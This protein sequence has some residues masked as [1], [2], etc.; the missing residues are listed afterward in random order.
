MFPRTPDLLNAI[1]N[2]IKLNEWIADIKKEN[3]GYIVEKKS[4]KSSTLSYIQKKSLP[5]P[6]LDINLT[7]DV[8]ATKINNK[9]VLQLKREH[10][11]G[12]NIS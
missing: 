10:L 7:D 3:K 2:E 9:T 11:K 6:K 8:I 1:C 5:S 4:P 12:I